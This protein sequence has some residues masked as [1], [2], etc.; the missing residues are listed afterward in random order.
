[1]SQA[2]LVNTLDRILAGTYDPVAAIVEGEIK[3]GF[4]VVR[5]GDQPWFRAN[6]WRAASVASIDGKR[7]RLVLIHSFESGKGAFTRT[8]AAIIAAGLTPSVIDPTPELSTALH[9]RGWRGRSRGTG[10]EDFETAWYPRRTVAA[11]NG[12]Q[13]DAA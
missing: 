9:R 5:P 3:R 8:V 2:A 1:M 11:S 7:V 6:D 12:N 10:F 4:K 13:G